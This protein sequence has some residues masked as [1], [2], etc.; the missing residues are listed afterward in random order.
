MIRHLP[1]ERGPVSSSKTEAGT[2][3]RLIAAIEAVW[4][5]RGNS[6][7]ALAGGDDC[8]IIRPA[9]SCDDLLL[10]TDQII[11]DRH[12]LRD[13]HPAGALGRKAL[14]RSLSDIAAMGGRPEFFLQTVCLPAWAVGSW[15][16]EFQ[17]GMRMAANQA[18]AERLALV[19]GDIASGGLFVATTTVIGKVE[20]GTALTRDGAQPGDTLHVSGSL[21][22][23]ALGLDILL[24][25]RDSAPDHP[26][27]RRH[28]E[29][30]PR[31]KLGRALRQVPASAAIDLSDGLAIDAN[32]LAAASEV[33]L[34]IDPKSIP[35]FPGAHA[36]SAIRSGEEYELLFTISSGTRIPAGLR[37]TL[38]GHVEAGTGVWLEAGRTRVPLS[39]EG[40]SHF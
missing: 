13:K 35:L 7:V 11:E 10:T 8:A 39:A 9:G 18:G 14:V 29:P 38:V 28:C 12:F 20:T 23:S 33:A 26:A 2:E 36:E 24:H 19:G 21:G 16:D 4:Q 37:Q 25:D 30:N 34:V 32:R 6:S 15:H 31:L 22:G 17:Q 1:P 40:F 5:G 3:S 27:V